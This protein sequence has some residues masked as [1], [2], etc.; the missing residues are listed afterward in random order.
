MRYNKTSIIFAITTAIL[1]LSSVIML[2]LIFNANN[3]AKII[4]SIANE[5]TQL[6]GLQGKAGDVHLHADFKVVMNGTEISFSKKEYD[7]RNA[8]VHLHL[9]QADGDKV[10]HLEAKRINLGHFFN[11]LGMK[12]TSNCF[13]ADG[14]KWCGGNGKELMLFVNGTR[15]LELDDYEPRNNDRMLLIYGSY[16]N[17]EL[18]EEINSVSEYSKKYR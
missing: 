15:N 2:V 11:T 7:E 4:A 6:S 16:S 17:K 13:E 3:S 9:G 8:F 12:L 1:L 18:K 5:L 14:K 10:I